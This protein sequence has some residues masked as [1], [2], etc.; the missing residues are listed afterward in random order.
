MSKDNDIFTAIISNP[1][2]AEVAQ[3]LAENHPA[4][5]RTRLL[6][7][8][9]ACEVDMRFMGLSASEADL[10]PLRRSLEAVHPA[11]RKQALGGT[12]RK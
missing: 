4:I 2:Q 3:W 10:T 7:I 9:H 6:E 12:I 5:S 11:W 1:R 8:I